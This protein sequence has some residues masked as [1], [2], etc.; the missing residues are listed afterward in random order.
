MPVEMDPL[1]AAANNAV[2]GMV[3]GLN[4]IGQTLANE[5]L[6]FS[7]LLLSV[8]L[9]LAPRRGAVRSR[10]HWRRLQPPRC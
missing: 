10:N 8:S 2:F 9:W 3:A 5:L 4:W 1:F 7:S 6:L